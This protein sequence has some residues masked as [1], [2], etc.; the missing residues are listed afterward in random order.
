MSFVSGPSKRNPILAGRFRPIVQVLAFVRKEIIAVARQPRLLLVLVLGPFLLLLLFAV[1]YDEEQTVLR[2]AFVGPEGSIYETATDRFGE[3]LAQYVEVVGFS[4]DL[5]AA[6]QR[7]AADEIDLVVV[8]PAE[9]AEM[10][11]EGRQAVITV[12][13]DKLDPIQQTAVEVSAQVAVQELNSMVLE[14]VVGELQTSLVPY[15]DGV[16]RTSTLVDEL[17]RAVAAGDQE[18]AREVAIELQDASSGL[19]AIVATTDA[20]STQ[21]GA[22]LDDDERRRLDELNT[23]VGRLDSTTQ[24]LATDGDEVTAQDVSQ[25]G[26][27]LELVEQQGETVTTLDPAVAVRPFVDD[28]ENLLRAPVTLNDFFAPAAIALLVQHMALTFAA[29]GLVRDRSLGLFE[30]FRVG[31]IGAGSILLG[32]YTAHM[33]LGTA[34]GGVL[35]TAVTL[36]VGVPQRGN[37]WW[38]ALGVFGLVSASIAWGLVLSLLARSDTQAVQYAMLALLAGLFF[39]GFLLDL[40]AIRYPVKLVSFLLPV[41]YGTRLLRDVMLRG[42]EPALLDLVGLGTTAAVMAVL[43]WL[44]M[45]RRLRQE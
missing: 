37:V 40:D 38:V 5:V 11:L 13:H 27:D 26:A 34:V 1:G 16:T 32:K 18:R 6:E 9:P 2:T 10:V 21:L 14:E 12:L 35:L 22:D 44:L 41:T 45:A 31:P 4:T 42:D 17:D 19:S 8:F 30:L 33:I 43:A 7:L 23:S 20:V 29:L 24:R 39:G 3:D 25:V 15:Q 36:G 28:T